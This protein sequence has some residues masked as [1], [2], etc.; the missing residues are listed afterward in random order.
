MFYDTQ[1]DTQQMASWGSRYFTQGNQ[2]WTL[3]TL[4]S[5]KNLETPIKKSSLFSDQLNGYKFFAIDFAHTYRGY[6]L[7]AFW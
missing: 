1:L 2:N 5:E 3:E 7:L 4:F 6:S